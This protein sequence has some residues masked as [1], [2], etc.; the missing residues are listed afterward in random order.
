[1]NGSFSF[2]YYWFFF[3]Y[4]SVI[5]FAILLP[6]VREGDMEEVNPY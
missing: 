3:Q 1:M 4:I 5:N 6:L 2:Y